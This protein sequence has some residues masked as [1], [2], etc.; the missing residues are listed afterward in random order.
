[1]RPGPGSAS[2]IANAQ[3]AHRRTCCF[4]ARCQQ[5]NEPRLRRFGG[6]LRG[7]LPT[8]EVIAATIS[9]DGLTVAAAFE[10]SAE[11]A[12]SSNY[13]RV[14]RLQNGRWNVLIEKIHTGSSGLTTARYGRA[15]GL[16]DDGKYLA[17]G[18]SGYGSQQGIAWV[19]DVEARAVVHTFSGTVAGD[20]AGYSVGIGL[21]DNAVLRLIVGAPGAT[22]H[23]QYANA[24]Q[25]F[26]FELTDSVWTQV[27]VFEAPAEGTAMPDNTEKEASG[28]P[29]EGSGTYPSPAGLRLGTAVSQ[30]SPLGEGSSSLTIGLGPGA[31]NLPTGLY[32]DDLFGYLPSS[33]TVEH[34]TTTAGLKMGDELLVLGFPE[35][36]PTAFFRMF[37]GVPLDDVQRYEGTVGVG[38]SGDARDALY[39]ASAG[40]DGVIRVAWLEAS[41]LGLARA[42]I[43][44]HRING[45]DD[46]R[47]YKFVSKTGTIVVPQRYTVEAYTPQS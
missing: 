7:R 1:M 25:L 34:A 27:A 39:T 35:G 41:I 12:A 32:V 43:R 9:A 13:V 21:N 40:V 11:D 33:G 47:P 20:E 42:E 19:W 8:D 6:V 36:Q 5:N 37:D 14:W 4:K 16:D 17:V 26:V 23:G 31:G 29:A 15:L 38:L 46:H 2:Q 44:G 30:T 18:D 28:A 24:G 22:T 3:A 10:D 45:D